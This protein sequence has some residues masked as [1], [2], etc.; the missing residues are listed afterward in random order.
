MADQ[1]DSNEESQE[2]DSKRLQHG[3]S[4]KSPPNQIRETKGKPRWMSRMN[5]K[6]RRGFG[7][8]VVMFFE[9]GCGGILFMI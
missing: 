2:E 8:F 3:P 1:G 4:L 9:A 5:I 6:L 7:L